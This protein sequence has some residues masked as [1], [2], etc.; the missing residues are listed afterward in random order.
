[1]S[2]KLLT[3]AMALSLGLTAVS[4]VSQAAEPKTEK[5]PVKTEA[6]TEKEP[7]ASAEEGSAKKVRKH[8]KHTKR[9]KAAKAKEETP[10]AE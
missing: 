7:T 9:H 2:K 3:W 4:F 6:K 8:R 5:A 10:K 1:M